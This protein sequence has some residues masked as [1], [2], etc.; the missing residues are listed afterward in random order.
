M[1]AALSVAGALLAH[2]FGEQEG[3]VVSLTSLWN[4][5]AQ[6]LDGAEENL[7]RAAH[8]E[9]DIQAAVAREDYDAAAE[10]HDT[11]HALLLAAP[12]S[13]SAGKAASASTRTAEPAA[14]QDSPDGASVIEQR[15]AQFMDGSWVDT[16]C[17]H[18]LAVLKTPAGEDTKLFHAW[19]RP[20][21]QELFAAGHWGDIRS[22][23][24]RLAGAFMPNE[25]WQP[26]KELAFNQPAADWTGVTAALEW[27]PGRNI[28]FIGDSTMEQQYRMTTCAAVLDGFV[29]TKAWDGSDAVKIGNITTEGQQNALVELTHP[30]GDANIAFW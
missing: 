21:S 6:L 16:G 14:T 26:R 2:G 9:R 8:L 29:V 4:K 12:V 18:C 13:Q 10:L 25:A 22:C 11:L 3:V 20:Q 5:D 28:L 24:G 27:L 7:N 17:A 19:A 23:S 30:K 15:L 1:R